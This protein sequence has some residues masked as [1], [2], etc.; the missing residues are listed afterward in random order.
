MLA[1]IVHIDDYPGKKT[2]SMFHFRLV[3][4]AFPVS[5]FSVGCGT[6]Q[7]CSGSNNPLLHRN[8]RSPPEI[9]PTT[10]RKKEIEFM[11]GLSMF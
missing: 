10:D 7:N 4:N 8:S 2:F 5:G 3:T 1:I 6:S 11:E 9:T